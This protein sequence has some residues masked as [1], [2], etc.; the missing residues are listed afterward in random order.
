MQLFGADVFPAHLEDTS[1]SGTG[2]DWWKKICSQLIIY[3]GGEEWTSLSHSTITNS[4]SNSPYDI[5]VS[6]ETIE[7]C[8]VGVQY[9]LTDYVSQALA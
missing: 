6:Y 4:G 7:R 2:S 5:I 9:V 8:F 3:F 1:L